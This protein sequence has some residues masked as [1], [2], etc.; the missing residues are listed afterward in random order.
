LGSVPGSTAGIVTGLAVDPNNPLLVYAS[1]SAFASGSGHHVFKSA[2]GANTWTDISGGLPIAPFVSV[3][4][5]PQNSSNLFAGSDVGIFASSDGGSTWSVFGPGLPN[6]AVD[7]MF[8]NAL[9]TALYVATHGRGM[10]TTPINAAALKV[11]AGQNNQHCGMEALNASTGAVVWQYQ[12]SAGTSSGVDPL[13]S[14]GV[15]YYFCGANLYELNATSGALITHFALSVIPGAALPAIANGTLYFGDTSNMYLYAVST[16]TGRQVWRY[17]AGGFI[18]AVPTVVNNVVY[19]Q[20]GDGY[21]YAVNAGTGRLVWRTQLASEIC[22]CPESSAAVVVNGVVYIG[23]YNGNVDA[24]NASNGSL[25]F[26][27]AASSG[28][29]PQTPIVMGGVVYI[30]AFYFDA[31]NAGTGALI[32]SYPNNELGPGMP[33][34]VNGVIYFA[35]SQSLEAHSAGMGALIWSRLCTGNQCPQW[36]SPVLASGLL[37][38]FEHGTLWALQA[39]NSATIWSVAGSLIGDFVA[40]GP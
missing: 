38:V 14:N 23:D 7:Q 6:V 9:G 5:N 20:A 34:G 24:V 39:S 28:G 15:V 10:W 36:N 32:W 3:L 8:I 4:V 26:S 37:Y 25:V 16:S 27:Y 21:L 17:K 40:V 2:D 18:G 33:A 1:F 12:D 13:L 29:I 22:D 11:Y 31:L 35:N 30:G 19:V